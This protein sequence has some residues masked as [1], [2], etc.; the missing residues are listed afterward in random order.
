[1]RKTAGV[2]ERYNDFL[3]YDVNDRQYPTWY[4]RPLK[5]LFLSIW[6]LATMT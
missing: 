6:R 5:R 3:L 1:V 4:T 2:E